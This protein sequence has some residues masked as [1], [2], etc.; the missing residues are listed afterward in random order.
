M[1]SLNKKI[2]YT[3]EEVIE[4]VK[5]GKFIIIVDYKSA[6]NEG[7]FFQAAEKALQES[8]NFLNNHGK[9]L[10]YLPCKQERLD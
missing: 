2:F 9:S 7:V 10:I 1:D 8:V 6:D 3:I 5:N 4:D